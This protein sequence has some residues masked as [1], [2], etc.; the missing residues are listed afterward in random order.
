MTERID[1]IVTALDEV[2]VVLKGLDKTVHIHEHTLRLVKALLAAFLIAIILAL[3]MLYRQDRLQRD[4]RTESDTTRTAL[5]AEISLFLQFESRMT[6]NPTYTPAQVAQQLGAYKILR[7]IHAD[8][9]C[10]TR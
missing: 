8:L 1:G 10:A 2:A 5:C 9:E 4:V 3:F 7:Q 6:S